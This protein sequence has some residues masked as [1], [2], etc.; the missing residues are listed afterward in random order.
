M[1]LG[2]EGQAI[3][4]RGGTALYEQCQAALQVQPRP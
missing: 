1:H 3:T 4:P 2:D